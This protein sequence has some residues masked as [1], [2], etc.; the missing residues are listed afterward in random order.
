MKLGEKL[1]QT[2]DD[3]ERAK[4]KGIGA[5]RQADMKKIKKERAN[6]KNWLDSVK[7][8][9]VSQIEASKVPFTKVTTYDRK[10]WLND[11]VEGKA[12]HQ[13]L[14]NDFRQYWRSEGLEPEITEAHDGMG[15]ESW[16][17]FTVKVLPERPRSSEV[18]RDGRRLGSGL[19]VWNTP[20]NKDQFE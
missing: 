13:D 15:K 20:G 14:W 9:F 7:G 2:L 4:I 6:I 17:N 10:K 5:R 12:E 18:K 11:A 1:K 19:Y 8:T 3:L 16:L